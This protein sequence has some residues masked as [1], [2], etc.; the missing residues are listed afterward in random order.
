MRKCIF[1]IP[2]KF[3]H[4]KIIGAQNVSYQVQVYQQ[5]QISYKIRLLAN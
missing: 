2:L 3:E 4:F 1:G 5:F